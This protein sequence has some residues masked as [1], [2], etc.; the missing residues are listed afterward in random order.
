MEE[1]PEVTV[2]KIE[3]A[4]ELV[5]MSYG[6]GAHA[7]TRGMSGPGLVDNFKTAYSSISKTVREGASEETKE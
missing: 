7:L 2:K 1:P 5:K 6:S 3:A 4:L